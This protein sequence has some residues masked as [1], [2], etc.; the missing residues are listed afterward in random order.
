MSRTKQQVERVMGVYPV[1]LPC[2]IKSLMQDIFTTLII[3]G[4]YASTN[5]M[6]MVNAL[7]VTETF[8]ATC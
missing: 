6:Y 4:G 7:S 3:I 8:T 1:G 2:V 5:P